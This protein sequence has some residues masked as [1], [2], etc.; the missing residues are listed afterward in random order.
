MRRI[1]KSPV[2]VQ[3]SPFRLHLLEQRSRRTR[4]SAILPVRAQVI[5]E[6][7]AVRLVIGFKL[8]G[9][10]LGI[11]HSIRHAQAISC[12][13]AEPTPIVTTARSNQTARRQKTL[14]R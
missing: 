3:Q 9:Y 7:D 1:V 14:S 13:V 11:S 12:Q 10:L 5:V 4:L 8:P 2:A 6:E